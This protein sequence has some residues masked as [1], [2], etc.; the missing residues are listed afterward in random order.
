MGKENANQGFANVTIA[1]M[2]LNAFQHLVTSS[3]PSKKDRQGVEGGKNGFP[4]N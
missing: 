4:Y 2:L 1:G 3:P